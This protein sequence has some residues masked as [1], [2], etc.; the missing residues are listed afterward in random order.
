MRPPFPQDLNP[1]RDRFGPGPDHGYA[2]SLGLIFFIVSLGALFTASMIGYIQYRLLSPTA[3]PAGSIHLPAGLWIS[4]AILI[5]S[6]ILLHRAAHAR[7]Q[8]AMGQ[9]MILAASTAVAFIIVQTPCMIHIVN[10]HEAAS[11]Q[12]ST[13]LYGLLM[14]LILLH[15]LHVVGG[16]AAMVVAAV[17]AWRRGSLERLAIRHCAWYWH[18][19]DIV[20][21][22]MF[23]TFVLTG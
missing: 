1:Y 22:I 8:A 2:R 13:G 7:T 19:L 12:F 11:S 18:F 10:Q 15:A 17:I 23:G 5:A 21:L 3:L 4:T 20:W 14:T 6:T 16:L 9:W